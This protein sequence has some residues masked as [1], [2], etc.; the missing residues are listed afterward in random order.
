[1]KKQVNFFGILA[2]LLRTY[3]IAELL[4]K[5]KQRQYQ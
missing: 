5:R 2:S 4:R 1:M 3:D